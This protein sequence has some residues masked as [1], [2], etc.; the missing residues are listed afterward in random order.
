MADNRRSLRQET[1][2]WFY[3][4]DYLLF[5]GMPKH[6]NHICP[7]VRKTYEPY[8]LRAL[9]AL[10]TES[11]LNAARWIG[12]IL[13]FT[14][15]TGS[16]P[17]AAEIN[18]EVHSKMEN[19]VDAKAIKLPDYRPVLLGKTDTEA[20]QGFQQRM[21]GLIAFSKQRAER[22]H[23]F[24]MGG[25]RPSTEPIV[26]ESALETSRVIADLLHTLGYL[27]QLPATANASISGRIQYSP[28]DGVEQLPAKVVLPGTPYS[29]LADTN[30]HY[31]FNHLPAG[32]YKIAA[33]LAGHVNA[34]ADVALVENQTATVDL[35]PKPT[36]ASNNLVRNS[37]LDNLWLG[38]GLTDAWYP[39]KSRAAAPHWEGEMLPLK[40][41]ATY[42]LSVEWQENAQ[43]QVVVRL[44]KSADFSK[45]P[46]ELPALQ[47]GQTSHTFQTS[48]DTAFAQLLIFSES[49]PLSVCRSV[50]L[51]EVTNPQ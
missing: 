29:T 30:G 47:H 1:G 44:R 48:A 50:S 4:D 38:T 37:S 42:R 19:W 22:A 32:T 8:F 25:D 28:I 24:V 17:H 20:L 3:A 11:P 2:H 39:I 41:G 49:D 43:G 45:V 40:G 35:K 21:E 5:P 26:L 36:A 10:R 13:H 16:P 15:D 51:S 6:L 34:R 23:P 27:A 9:Q 18:G 46:E 33:V 14:E 12:S 7:E 31:A